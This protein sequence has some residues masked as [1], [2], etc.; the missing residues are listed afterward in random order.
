MFSDP[1]T[2]AANISV[3]ADHGNVTLTGQ[4]PD[5]ATRDE[6]FKVAQQTTG[7]KNVYDRMAIQQAAAALVPA[8]Q[9]PPA[10][11]DKRIGRFPWE[12]PR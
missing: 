8:P 5:N 2:K 12:Q 3:T 7:V 6:V 10:T 9:A 4:V 1:Q 11:N